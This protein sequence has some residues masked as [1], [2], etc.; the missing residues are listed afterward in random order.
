MRIASYESV[1]LLVP[2]HGNGATAQLLDCVVHFIRVSLHDAGKRIV[3]FL[4]FANYNRLE[5]ASRVLE[6]QVGLARQ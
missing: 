6:V 2:G 1:P 4:D 5:F 3:R